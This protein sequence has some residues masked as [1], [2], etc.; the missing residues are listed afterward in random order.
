[1]C[2]S[3]YGFPFSL[4]P[5]NS[6]I[7]KHNLLHHWYNT[8][9]RF[10]PRIKSD[11]SQLGAALHCPGGMAVVIRGWNKSALFA[12]VCSP[13]ARH[14]LIGCDST[15]AQCALGSRVRWQL[16]QMIRRRAG[17]ES[18]LAFCIAGKVA[19]VKIDSLLMNAPQKCY[20]LTNYPKTI[21]EQGGQE[22]NELCLLWTERESWC[23]SP[24]GGLAA[25]QGKG[26]WM[27]EQFSI[28]HQI[29]IYRPSCSVVCSSGG[30]A[31][32]WKGKSGWLGAGWWGEM[33]R[34]GGAGLLSMLLGDA[35]TACIQ[36]HA[37]NAF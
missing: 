33:S 5:R 36:I 8:R 16:S 7:K 11:P 15:S 32:M 17:G 29:V 25:W 2:F 3:R 30:A 6:E 1:M 23:I 22:V 13:V 14:R 4:Q 34:R 37:W 28:R 10:Q 31:K 9:R 19:S 27:A 20:W 26:G 35:S 12:R 18:K 21:K 24:D